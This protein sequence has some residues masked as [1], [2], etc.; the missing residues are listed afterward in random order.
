[1][2]NL[3]FRV[4]SRAKSNETNK[5][6][7]LAAFANNPMAYNFAYRCANGN[8]TNVDRN[9]DRFVVVVDG[10]PLEGYGYGHSTG[11]KASLTD[12]DKASVLAEVQ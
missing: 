10:L 3:R 9:Y 5:V 7:L 11:V 2:T 6:K 1:M 12:A 8:I 4:Y